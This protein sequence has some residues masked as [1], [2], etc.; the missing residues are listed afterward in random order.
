MTP[1]N[2]KWLAGSALLFLS[3]ALWALESDR[4]QPIAIEADQGSLDQ[5]SQTTTFTGNVKLR[6]GTMYVNA[7]RVVAHK[8]TAG[9]QI[10]N[11]SG[12]PVT[13][14]QQLEKKGLVKG[15]GNHV[16]YESVSGIVTLTGNA[17]VQRGGDMASGQTIVYNTRTEVY[18]VNS[19]QKGRVHVIIQPQN[20]KQTSG[21]K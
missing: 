11:A 17:K 6:Q 12:S 21:K 13:F 9:N 15:Q 16:H 5:N 1:K 19:A 7:A 14:G 2:L 3:P 20:K 4:N 8:D 10:I 18:T